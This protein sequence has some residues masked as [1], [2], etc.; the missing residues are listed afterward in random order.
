LKQPL[1]K[2]VWR[3]FKKLQI[4]LTYVPAI[5]LV[6]KYPEKIIIE[7]KTKQNKNTCTPSVVAALFTVAS[8]WKQPRFH[9]QMNG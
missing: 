6:I 7:N 3:F 2:I 4:K 9:Q 5:P 1:W 8:T